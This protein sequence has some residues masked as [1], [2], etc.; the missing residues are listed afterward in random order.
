MSAAEASPSAILRFSSARASLTALA[1]SSARSRCGAGVIVA[2]SLIWCF[3]SSHSVRRGGHMFLTDGQGLARP[4]PV[5]PRSAQLLFPHA[6]TRGSCTPISGLS[7]RYRPLLCSAVWVERRYDIGASNSNVT[8]AA[9]ALRA[10]FFWSPIPCASVDKARDRTGTGALPSRL[11]WAHP[12]RFS[13][14]LG[15]GLT[16][17][18]GAGRARSRSSA[19]PRRRSRAPGR[20]WRD[21]AWPSRSC[22]AAHPPAAPRD[23]ARR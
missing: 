4:P 5:G 7:L 10:R 8:S 9:H 22:A 2:V 6:E 13:G 18:P 15:Q 16:R 12:K 1:R 19:L 20:A 14:G 21:R 3:A 11:G 23:G 17:V